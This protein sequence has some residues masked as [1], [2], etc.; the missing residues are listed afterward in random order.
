MICIIGGNKKSCNA[1]EELV[2]M[3]SVLELAGSFNDAESLKNQIS[4]TDGYSL[5]FIDIDT[6]DPGIL[7]MLK[8]HSSHPNIIMISSSDQYALKAFDLNIIDYLVKPVQFARFS[9]AIDKV[10]RYYSNKEV[11]NKSDN[12]IF[13]KKGSSLVKL[14]VK[15]IVYV[16]AL[17]NYVTL[18]T[19]DD[20]FL[21]HFTMKGIESQLPSGLFL[22]IHRS[23]IVNKSMIQTISENTLDINIKGNVKSLSVGKSYRDNLMNEINLM[24]RK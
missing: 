5:I 1:I 14:R 3:S 16:E 7:D 12:Q 20:R 15:D 23:F 13:I 4:R 11:S 17:E 21:I 19:I 2:R 18:N 6:L 24:N 8:D 10:S 9:K 22:R